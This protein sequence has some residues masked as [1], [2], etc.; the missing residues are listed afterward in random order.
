MPILAWLLK[1]PRNIAIVLL[2]LFVIV[3]GGLYLYQRNTVTSLKGQVTVLKGNLEAEKKANQEL[4]SAKSALENKLKALQ[5]IEKKYGDIQKEIDI[6]KQTCPK[7]IVVAQPK[8]P[9]PPLKPGEIPLPAPSPSD[10]TP[11]EGQPSQI[12]TLPEGEPELVD[13]EWGGTEYEKGS[14]QVYNKIT[15]WFN[16]QEGTKN[17]KV[18]NVNEFI[19]DFSGVCWDQATSPNPSSESGLYQADKANFTESG[20]GSFLGQSSQFQQS[21]GQLQ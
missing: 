18:S 4:N 21:D 3:I 10:T 14:I 8:K 2:T 19:D 9:A 12:N 15:D 11:S 1:D 17:E 16:S 7:K 6:L 20:N 13:Y 5:G